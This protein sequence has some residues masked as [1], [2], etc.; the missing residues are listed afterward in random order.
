MIARL[1]QLRFQPAQ[2]AVDD[3]LHDVLRADGVRFI[4]KDN[5]HTAPA[6][7]V[8]GELLPAGEGLGRLTHWLCRFQDYFSR[9]CRGSFF[10][11]GGLFFGG[12]DHRIRD[13][14]I[15]FGF[16]PGFVRPGFDQL[17]DAGADHCGQ[18]RDLLL[19][20]GRHSDLCVFFGLFCH[21]F[22]FPSGRISSQN[23]T[24]LEIKYFLI[25]KYM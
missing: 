13:Q 22:T 17:I 9:A 24:N 5:F 23:V 1:L 19:R 4:D 15:L 18:N 14:P 2:I 16:F 25:G 21:S 6:L 20:G 3:D 10:F 8:G 11:R 7:Y 12:L